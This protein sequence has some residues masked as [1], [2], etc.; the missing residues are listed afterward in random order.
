MARLVAAPVLALALV[1]CGDAGTNAAEC[2]AA[3]E[4]EAAIS[5]RL[6]VQG[7]EFLHHAFA[8]A[9]PP[10][11]ALDFV[12][13]AEIDGAGFM[14]EGDIGLWAVDE[15]R[16]GPFYAVNSV[17]KIPTNWHAAAKDGL[18]VDVGNVAG[19]V[20]AYSASVCVEASYGVRGVE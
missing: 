14:G 20:Q 3:P 9:L 6:A 17:A 11:S 15:L 10:S 19:S 16:D 5:E 13:A 8:V 2:I 18:P 12:V 4:S 1:A 7:G